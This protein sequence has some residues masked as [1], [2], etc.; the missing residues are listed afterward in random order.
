MQPKKTLSE[1]VDPQEETLDKIMK[2]DLIQDKSADEIKEIWQQYHIN[3]DVIAATIPASDYDAISTSAK[4][5]PIF[6]FP[7]PRSQGYEFIMAQFYGNVVHFTPL[8][9]YQVIYI[10][11]C[12]KDIF[13]T[14]FLL[15][16]FTK[17][18]HQNA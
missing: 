5:S 9:C 10:E 7:L 2:V 13:D 11:I 4:N 16:R 14:I 6:I 17:R 8:I 15:H 3:K 1:K 12:D 18:M